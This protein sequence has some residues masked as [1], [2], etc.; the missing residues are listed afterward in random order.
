MVSLIVE[1]PRDPDEVIVPTAT[2][3][4]SFLP[5]GPL[6]PSPAALLGTART[7]EL[8]S[9]LRDRFDQLV[10][11]TPP[12]NAGADVTA[13]GPALDGLVLVV[14][15]NHCGRRAIV[16]AHD[17]IERS[18]ARLLGIVVN[19]VRAWDPH[20]GLSGYGAYVPASDGENGTP[21]AGRR[22]PSR[23]RGTR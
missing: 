9:E 10:V 17:Q 23:S 3:G 11:D 18:G 7:R 14:D 13:L 16:A 19:R 15:L 22:L 1:A 20:Y 8:L 6:P 5:S 4:I 12:V 2:R 21:K